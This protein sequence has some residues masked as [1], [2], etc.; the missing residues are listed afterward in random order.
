MVT[1][2]IPL[3]C[4]PELVQV[5]TNLHGRRT[6]ER[7]RF[8]DVWGVHVY[9]YAGTLVVGDRRIAFTAGDLTITPADTALEWIF[10]AQAPH[11]Y[12]LLR[13]P[14]AG[15]ADMLRMPAHHRPDGAMAMGIARDFPRMPEVARREPVCVAV[16]FWNLLWSLATVPGTAAVAPTCVVPEQPGLR[17]DR[18]H[19]VVQT[20]L[21]V[22]EEELHLRPSLAGL[23]H[24]LGV[25]PNHLLRLF[26]AHTGQTVMAWVRARRARKA[27]LL[28]EGG[29]LPLSAV[30]RAVGASDLQ[31]LNKLLRSAF[32]R[33]PRALRGTRPGTDADDA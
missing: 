32:G 19:P 1:V 6:H 18:V 14:G 11:H 12:A 15:P 24:R 33:S 26:R 13:F 23:A 5:G 22:I 27:R 3:R 10:P 25:S 28:V 30:A 16:W 17:A 21:V 29:S 20:A 4:R 2:S 9:D 8:A 31:R 7:F